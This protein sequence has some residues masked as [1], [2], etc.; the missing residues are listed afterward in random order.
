MRGSWTT[1]EEIRMM[2]LEDHQ[3]RHIFIGASPSSN[4]GPIPM[5]IGGL[6]GKKDFGKGG[7]FGYFKGKKGKRKDKKG[8]FG[9]G[10]GKIV[11]MN[12]HSQAMIKY[13]DKEKGKSKIRDQYISNCWT[14]GKMAILYHNALRVV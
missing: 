6:K 14:C 10:K 4:Q 12:F 1:Y 8:K 13:K 2:I 7:D 3:S 9:K 11:Y 5:D